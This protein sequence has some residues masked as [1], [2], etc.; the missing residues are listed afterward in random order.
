MP[1]DHGS[2]QGRRP[3]YHRGRRGPDRRGPERRT[4]PNPQE[5][6]G[7]D[8]FDVEQIMRDIRS[9]ISKRHGIDLT[10]QQIHELA[11]RRLE[12]IL[13]PRHVSPS[14]MEQMRRAAGEAIEV[15]A[16]AADAPA[17]T[18]DES[19]LYAS[20]RGF[21]NTL[22]R[23]LNPV[24]KLFINPAPLVEAVRAQE[25]RSQAAASREA[26]LYA[27]QAEWNALHYEV[28]QRLVT[29]VSRTALE[30]QALTTRI[31]SLAAKVDFNERRVRGLESSAYQSARPGPRPS[32]STQGEPV[33]PA[34]A[35]SAE[36]APS[37]APATEGAPSEGTRRRRRRRR[38]RRSGLPPSAGPGPVG[39]EA[40][41]AGLPEMDGDEAD[42]DSDV[43]LDVDADS[44]EPEPAAEASSS[45]RHAEDSASLEPA[46]TFSL[47][48][49]AERHPSVEADSF[50]QRPP[51]PA[52]AP[53][54]PPADAPVQPTPPRDEPVPPAPVDR[55]DSGPPDR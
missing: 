37:A 13:E 31:E 44:S 10:P 27:R 45:E 48:Q 52:P 19:S 6:T 9:R 36:G 29:E 8:H 16:P 1:N 50:T 47:L 51:E 25:R 41:P 14:L 54:S 55:A 22:R 34:A 17:A 2:S 46:H 7:R 18:F 3:H 39:T 40:A 32:D 33:R 35:P 28:V 43:D 24:L 38:G 4:P 15:P 5:Q 53:P 20:H 11:A 42:G 30:M 26:E 12:A 49:P 21:L 23:W